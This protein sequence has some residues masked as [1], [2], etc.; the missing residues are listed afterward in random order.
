MVYGYEAAYDM[1]HHGSFVG[2]VMGL[3]PARRTA[4]GG[5]WESGG[6]P[7]ASAPSVTHTCEPWIREWKPGGDGKQECKCFP[8]PQ[9]ASLHHQLHGRARKPLGAFA[10]ATWQQ[11][12]GR[13]GPA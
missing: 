7:Q 13:S 5:P 2:T 3:D 10:P 11:L 6:V 1:Q 12:I 8:W 9:A 4:G